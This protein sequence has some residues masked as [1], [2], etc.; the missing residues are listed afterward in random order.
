MA[1]GGHGHAYLDDIEPVHECA[2]AFEDVACGEKLALATR[3]G[4]KT[5]S[6]FLKKASSF[7]RKGLFVFS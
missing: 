4:R 1:E 5:N 7:L 2:Y 6:P 3:E